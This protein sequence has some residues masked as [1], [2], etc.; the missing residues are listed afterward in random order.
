MLLVVIVTVGVVLGPLIVDML[1]TEDLEVQ[2]RAAQTFITLIKRL[3]PAVFA[4]FVLVF[5]HQ[6]LITHRICG[7]LV[8]F[9]NTFK[10]VAEGDLTR[11]IF[12]RQGDYLRE[13]CK[14]INEM[15][16]GLSSHI[17][18][19][20]DNHKRLIQLLED[21]LSRVD[22]P[23]ACLK[24]DETLEIIKNEAKLVAEELQIF[25]IEKE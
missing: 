14:R 24:L 11:K 17:M 12:L 1:M 22:D 15:V 13:E 3:V 2:Y 10:K 8:N 16:D 7:P 6:I 4:I 19:I 21:I 20:G 18:R 25:R 9:N 23:D 5:I